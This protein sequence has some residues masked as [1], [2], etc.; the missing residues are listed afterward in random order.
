MGSFTPIRLKWEE[1]L[2]QWELRLL[3]VGIEGTTAER[4]LINVLHSPPSWYS[5]E[6]TWALM[7]S[8]VWYI[9]KELIIRWV[10][11][12]GALNKV[13]EKLQLSENKDLKKIG[14]LMSSITSGHGIKLPV[15]WSIAIYR[16]KSV[17]SWL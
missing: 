3:L 11:L 7:V 9:L 12:R 8:S 14:L 5:S 10:M 15:F 16:R 17:L 2:P 6:E 13:T 1:R 4:S